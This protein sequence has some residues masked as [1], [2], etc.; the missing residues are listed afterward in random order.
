MVSALIDHIIFIIYWKGFKSKFCIKLKNG[1]TCYYQT[2][3]NDPDMHGLLTFAECLNYHVTFT[4][5]Q[6][7]SRRWERSLA[8]QLCLLSITLHIQVCISN[9]LITNDCNNTPKWKHVFWF[10]FHIT[11]IYLPLYFVHQLLI[12]LKEGQHPRSR[13]LCLLAWVFPSSMIGE[14]NHV[15]LT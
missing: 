9:C 4:M 13:F 7:E 10:L 15:M 3:V 5:K 1:H 11:I 6:L 12:D 14:E 2:M 8:F